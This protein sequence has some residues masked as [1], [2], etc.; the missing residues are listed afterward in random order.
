MKA[1]RML[2][3]RQNKAEFIPKTA[4]QNTK[5]EKIAD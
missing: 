4:E 1:R 3:E 2:R 5:L